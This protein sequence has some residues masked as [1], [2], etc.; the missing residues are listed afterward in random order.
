MFT[1]LSKVFFTNELLCAFLLSS[2]DSHFK[3]AS[4]SELDEPLE[5][6]TSPSEAI[7]GNCQRTFGKMT[8]EH[9][10]SSKKTTQK[11]LKK[12][13]LTIYCSKCMC[14]FYLYWICLG[15]LLFLKANC[16]GCDWI[17]LVMKLA[18]YP[19]DQNRTRDIDEF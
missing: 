10:G 11:T 16:H 13:C 3:V 17:F 12:Q 18:K 19:R 15:H 7:L 6:F 8:Y 4:A 14:N 5:A 9:I 1:L 2:S